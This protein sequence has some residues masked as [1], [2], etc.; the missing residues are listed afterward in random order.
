M[1]DRAALSSIDARGHERRP[2]AR[3]AGARGRPKRGRA[4]SVPRAAAQSRAC[5]PGASAGG[6]R[7]LR[8]RARPGPARARHLLVA[9]FW[10]AHYEW[11]AHRKAAIELGMSPAISDAIA[12]SLRP[13]AL[14]PDEALATSSA[15]NCWPTRTSATGPIGRLSIVS[16][17]P[18]S[19]RWWRQPAIMV[20][21]RSSSTS[22]ARL[23]PMDPHCRPCDRDVRPV[24]SWSPRCVQAATRSSPPTSA[25]S[26]AF[27]PRRC[28][29]VPRSPTR[30]PPWSTGS[31]R[32]GIDIVNEGEYT[33]GG[34]WLSYVEYRF[35]GFEER[36]PARTS[37]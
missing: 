9:R 34:D 3:C 31:G 4:R 15:R 8:E 19:S 18:P 1:H 35:G 27:R 28:R 5:R 24:H 32:F 13:P 22:T 29:R 25:A 10:S 2:E 23:L 14:S 11:Y 17:R 16:A 6:L 33:K 36:P 12:Q 26:R 30:L 21:F 7:P 37:R 20:S